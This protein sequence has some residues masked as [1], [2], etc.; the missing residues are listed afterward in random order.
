MRIDDMRGVILAGGRSTRMGADKCF[1]T[2]GGT[3]LLRR[4]FDIVRPQVARMAIST[5]VPAWRFAD[6]DADIV[7]DRRLDVQGPLAGIDAAFARFPDEDL[8]VVAVDVPFIPGDLGARLRRPGALCRFAAV[9]ERHVLALWLN[10]R[11]H[12]PLLC[13]LDAG[14]RALKGFLRSHG[15]AVAFDDPRL[16]LNLNTPADVGAAL[17]L[18]R[19]SA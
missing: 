16:G 12:T 18:L 9:E 17:R 11:A 15:E 13:Y 10:A 14:G 19:E 7:A 8:L 3:S 4:A 2:F 1:L 6:F 5:N